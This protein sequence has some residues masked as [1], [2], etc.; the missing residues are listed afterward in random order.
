MSASAGERFLKTI[1]III[2]IKKIDFCLRI[3]ARVSRTLMRRASAVTLRVIL[4][5]TRLQTA[6]K[7]IS[8]GKFFCFRFNQWLTR[9]NYLQSEDRKLSY[10]TYEVK[11]HQFKWVSY[12]SKYHRK[13]AAR[14]VRRYKGEISNG[15]MYRK[16]YDYYQSCI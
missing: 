14:H 4:D 2:V 15:G 16:I 13:T 12:H 10:I 5:T 7:S 1:E 6:K 8:A 3:I 9:V 11:K